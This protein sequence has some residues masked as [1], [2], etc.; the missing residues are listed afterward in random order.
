MAPA[1]LF[2]AAETPKSKWRGILDPAKLQQTRRNPAVQ[3]HP[4]R[5]CEKSECSCAA[6]EPAAILLGPL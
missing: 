2:Q 4:C 1:K 5:I 6:P 3:S